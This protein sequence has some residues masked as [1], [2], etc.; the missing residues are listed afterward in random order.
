MMA[1]TLV[2][3]D[4]QV[5]I[6]LKQWNRYLQKITNSIFTYIN[7]QTKENDSSL[8]ESL[9]KYKKNKK[10]LFVFQFCYI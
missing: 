6:I 1:M 9:K 5:K 4:V 10:F 2:D 8:T 3:E 7:P